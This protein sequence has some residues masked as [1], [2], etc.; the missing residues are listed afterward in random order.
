MLNS[1]EIAI[2]KKQYKSKENSKL[3]NYLFLS[4]KYQQYYI[5]TMNSFINPFDA[6]FDH[7][8]RHRR[9]WHH[10]HPYGGPFEHFRRHQNWAPQP[11]GPEI[12][13]FGNFW[14]SSEFGHSFGGRGG[15]GRHFGGRGGFGFH[16]PRGGFGAF[17]GAFGRRGEW[18]LESSDNSS[19]SEDTSENTS[20]SDEKCLKEKRG[21]KKCSGKN[22]HKF[23]Q[24]KWHQKYGREHCHAKK[25]SWKTSEIPIED[26]TEFGSDF[27]D[28]QNDINM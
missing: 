11:F 19:S 17:C 13:E 21:N 16:S 25:G 4:V 23:R 6:S 8:H 28:I 27:D 7:G 5:L 15:F 22:G 9:H 10:H 18:K 3:K 26:V 14:P 2:E 1:G 24:R 12:T 20:D